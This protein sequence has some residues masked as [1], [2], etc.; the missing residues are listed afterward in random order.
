MNLRFSNKYF[1][2]FIVT[3]SLLLS[4]LMVATRSH[5]FAIFN[6]LPSSSLAVFFLAGMYVRKISVFWYFYLLTVVIDLS[7][8]YLRGQ[9]V[10]YLTLSYSLLF[11]AYAAMY[12]AGFYTKPNWLVGE[13]KAV[14]KI[15]FWLLLAT[16]LA[17]FISNG[18]FYF[19]SGSY[20]NISWLNYQE[21]I[22]KYFLSYIDN[23]IFYVFI[24]VSVDFI[25]N[26]IPTKS[27]ASIP[28][29][30]QTLKRQTGKIISE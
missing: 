17:F 5:H 9:V 25:I 14:G 12:I 30:P 8:S 2:S 11:F 10:N 28:I 1:L 15:T 4:L 3:F 23:P 18:S 13:F 19:L 20:H 7:S 24:T 29:K 16:S 26:K 6:Q 27:P 22:D 21:Q